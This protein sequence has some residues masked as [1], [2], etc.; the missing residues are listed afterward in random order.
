MHIFEVVFETTDGAVDHQVVTDE[1][2][3]SVRENWAERDGATEILAVDSLGPFISNDSYEEVFEEVKARG[4]PD[5]Y[6]SD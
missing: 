4:V 1:D 3:S 2:E 6:T 5:E